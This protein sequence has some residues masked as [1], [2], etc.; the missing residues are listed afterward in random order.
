MSGLN[1]QDTRST[2]KLQFLNEKTIKSDELLENPL[3]F[4]IVCL[5]TYLQQICGFPRVSREKRDFLFLKSAR[6]RENGGYFSEYYAENSKKMSV[7]PR[8]K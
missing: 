7:E 8:L 2:Q 4:L 6:K 1:D 5:S 3:L